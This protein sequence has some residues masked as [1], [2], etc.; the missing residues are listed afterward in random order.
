MSQPDEMPSDERIIASLDAVDATLAGEPVDPSYADLAEVALL[1]ADERPAVDPDFA[2][3]LDQAVQRRF[4]PVQVGT[5]RRSARILPALRHGWWLWTPAAGLGVA[6]IAAVVIVAAGGTARPPVL[7][8]IGSAALPS[9]SAGHAAGGGPSVAAASGTPRRTSSAASTK[10]AASPALSAPS[11]VAGGSAVGGAAGAALQPPANGRK[12]IQSAQLALSTAPDRLEVV[13]QE[14]FVV[15]GQVQGIVNSSNVTAT[16]GPGGYAQFQLSIPS[17]VLPQA[18]ASLS[19][20]RYAR[21]TSRTDTTQ[22]VNDQYQAALRALSD[23][24]ALRTSLLKQLANATTQAQIDSL[25]A[26][27]HDA[28]ASISSD[29]AALRVLN[30]QINYSQVGLTINGGPVPV[31][32]PA[33][34]SGGGFGIGQAAHDAGRVLTVA[35][36]VA[37]IGAAALVPVALLVALV[38]WIAGAIRRRRREQALDLA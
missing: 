16:S 7:R 5:P 32:L 24:R 12:I 30:H 18:M 21:V 28:E 3:R 23:A 2:T 6:L 34:T 20:L 4:V 31:P 15:V 25:T 1:L 13:A 33:Q 11:S 38:W 26:R 9:P 35:A 14:V 19:T 37:L 27:I 10:A 8:T 22:D 29:A 17:A 36:G